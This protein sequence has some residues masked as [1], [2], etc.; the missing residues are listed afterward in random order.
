MAHLSAA[1]LMIRISTSQPW[2]CWWWPHR[3]GPGCRM[4]VGKMS[5]PSHSH[6]QSTPSR[7]LYPPK[8]WTLIGVLTSVNWAA[9]GSPHPTPWPVRLSTVRGSSTPFEKGFNLQTLIN[10]PRVPG[11]MAV[12]VCSPSIFPRLTRG[13]LGAS[14]PK[15]LGRVEYLLTLPNHRG[16]IRPQESHPLPQ[17]PR[18]RRPHPAPFRHHLISAPPI[19]ADKQE[20]PSG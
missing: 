3:F 6:T 2:C 18:Q 7:Y 4:V 11:G 9:G 19:I 17:F 14:V 15:H 10:Q 8:R 12:M 5:A 13:E 16:S 1:G 20:H